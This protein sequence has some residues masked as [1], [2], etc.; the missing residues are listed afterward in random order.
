MIRPNY[1]TAL[2]LILAV[3]CAIILVCAKTLQTYLLCLILFVIAAFTDLWD[4][5]I[6]RRFKM[7]SKLGK[8]ADPIADKVLA[9]SA[10]F[11]IAYRGVYS[12]WWVVP[13]AIREVSVTLARLQ[14][15]KEGYVVSAEWAGKLKATIQYVTISLAF[16]VLVLQDFFNN[17]FLYLTAQRGLIL[18]LILTN[19]ITL[20]S[21]VLFFSKLK[22]VR[23]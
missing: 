2:R 1:L 4:G 20:Y 3:T 17:H 9:L 8:I 10:F 22:Q 23:T 19:L 18:F 5:R 12:V 21:G 6:A 11:T 16:V 15:V 7:E 14:L 13:I